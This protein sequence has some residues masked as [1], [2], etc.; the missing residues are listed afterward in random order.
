MD[1]GLISNLPFRELLQAHEDYS[2]NVEGKD[3]IPDLELY[4]VNLHTSRINS[5]IP[6]MDHDGVRGRLNDITFSDRAPIIY[7][8]PF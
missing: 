4:M 6:P 1:G 2:V 3:K 5:P 8:N 7:H